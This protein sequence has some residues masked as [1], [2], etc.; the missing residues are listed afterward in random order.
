MS[1]LTLWWIGE[2]LSSLAVSGFYPMAYPMASL[3]VAPA[4]SNQN[5]FR[6]DGMG[7]IP[8]RSRESMII[9]PSSLFRPVPILS[10]PYPVLSLL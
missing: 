1:R 8:S 2:V 5:V 6:R 10:H 4:E 3:T 9:T 7:Q